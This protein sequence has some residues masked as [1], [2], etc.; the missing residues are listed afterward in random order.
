MMAVRPAKDFALGVAVV[1][2]AAGGGDDRGSEPEARGNGFCFNNGT[3]RWAAS[4]S[5]FENGSRFKILKSTPLPAR[6][7]RTEAM[8]LPPWRK[9]RRKANT[10]LVTST[11]RSPVRNIPPHLHIALTDY[12]PL[13]TI[14]P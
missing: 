7:L 9:L 14:K 12:R 4:S 6:F 10:A 2:A 5:R 3:V 13:T 1:L 11:M 8:E